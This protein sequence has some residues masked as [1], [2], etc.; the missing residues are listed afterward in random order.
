RRLEEIRAE[1]SDLP[2]DGVIGPGSRIRGAVTF[3]GLDFA[4]PGGNGRPTLRGIDLEVPPGSTVGIVGRVGSGKSTL[5]SLIAAVHAVRDGA[6]LIDGRDL[7]SL[8]TAHLRAHVGI[9][10]QETFLFSRT[11]AEN[12][13]LG[14]P[15]APRARLEEAARLAQVS[16]DLQDLPHGLDTMVGERG[17]TLSG[18][19]RQRVALARALL[20]DPPILILD[21]ALSSVDADTEEAILRGLRGVMRGRTTFLISHRVS[22]VLGADRIVVLEDGRMA[23]SGTPAELLARDGLF[24]RMYRQQQIERELETL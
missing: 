21:D 13:A 6:I 22:T 15:Q 18:G 16:R 19:Q 8:P 7:N 20:L 11:I 2:G 10:P 5:V 17:I 12:I 1:R 24:A 4:Y 9:V 3:N 14:A 23:E